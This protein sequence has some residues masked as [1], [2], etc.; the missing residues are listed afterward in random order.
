VVGDAAI[1]VVWGMESSFCTH[2]QF[3]GLLIRLSRFQFGLR[4]PQAWVWQ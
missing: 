2:V 3:D 1:F 4:R